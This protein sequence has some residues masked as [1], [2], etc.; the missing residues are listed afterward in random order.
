LAVGLALLG[1]AWRRPVATA[2]TVAAIVAL[3]VLTAPLL[4]ATLL[5]PTRI[6]AAY[7][8]IPMPDF[9][10]LNIWQFT[11]ERI[12]ERPLLGWGMDSARII[13]G[14]N[15]TV[16]LILPSADGARDSEMAR[17]PLHPHNVSLQWWLELGLPGA[18]LGAGLLV[19]VILACTA[20]PAGAPVAVAAAGAATLVL[21]VSYG[22]WQS[23]WLGTLWLLAAAFAALPPSRRRAGTSGTLA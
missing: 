13:P 2:R 14:G 12:A 6:A 4:S 16:R 22:A 9:H 20:L 8:S 3:G 21:M 19:A 1:P 17:M 18:L 5:E 10:R 11:T 7:P 23:W 15:E